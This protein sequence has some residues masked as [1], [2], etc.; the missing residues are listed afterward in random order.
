MTIWVERAGEDMVGLERGSQKRSAASEVL[1]SPELLMPAVGLVVS[2]CAAAVW[3]G[4]A[5]ADGDSWAVAVRFA[6]GVAA[7][8]YYIAVFYYALDNRSESDTKTL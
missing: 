2:L 8:T 5:A 4:L 1:K 3:T 7:A 6:V